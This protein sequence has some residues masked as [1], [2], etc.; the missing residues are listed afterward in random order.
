[1]LRTLKEEAEKPE[2]E[3]KDQHRKLWEG[4][5]LCPGG[6][7]TPPWLWQGRVWAQESL[8]QYLLSVVALIC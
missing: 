2:K 1:M 6:A 4:T 7:V 3:A 8:A 5:S